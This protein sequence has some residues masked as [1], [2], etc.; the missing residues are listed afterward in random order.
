MLPCDELLLVGGWLAPVIPLVAVGRHVVVLV[1]AR[2]GI[3]DLT[4][5]QSHVAQAR[6]LVH[7]QIHRARATLCLADLACLE[8]RHRTLE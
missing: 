8:D 7:E 6:E 4:C 3:Q 1:C 5:K 2:A